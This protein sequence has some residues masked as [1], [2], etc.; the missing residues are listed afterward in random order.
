LI[1]QAIRFVFGNKMISKTARISID[2]ESSF[3]ASKITK[4][5]HTIATTD[6]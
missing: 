2:R 1:S 6:P 3:H 5:E 4:T